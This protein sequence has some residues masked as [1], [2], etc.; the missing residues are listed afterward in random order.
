MRERY[1]KHSNFCWLLSTP[2]PAC[3]QMYNKQYQ[4][5]YFQIVEKLRTFE[6]KIKLLYILFNTLLILNV[7]IRYEKITLLLITWKIMSSQRVE[8][9]QIVKYQLNHC[10]SHQWPT[11]KKA[12]VSHL[13]ISIVFLYSQL[14]FKLTSC[15]SSLKTENYK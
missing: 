10:Q 4:N 12:L 9:L 6:L 7:V 2:H 5:N 13:L 14:G 11:N 15:K 3:L 1:C 8:N